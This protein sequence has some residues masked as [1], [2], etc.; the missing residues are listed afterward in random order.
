MYIFNLR[1]LNIIFTWSYFTN[2][3]PLIVVK[4]LVKILLTVFKLPVTLKEVGVIPLP[5]VIKRDR[6]DSYCSALRSLW[7]PSI[8]F[9]SE[10]LGRG[11]D[12]LV[13]SGGVGLIIGGILVVAGICYYKYYGVLI[14]HP[15]ISVVD[16]SVVLNNTVVPAPADI[17]VHVA[18]AVTPVIRDYSWSAAFAESFSPV[19]CVVFV[20]S[21]GLIALGAGAFIMQRDQLAKE[22][23]VVKATKRASKVTFAE[24]A[25]TI[26]PPIVVLTAE[27]VLL[28]SK[29][30]A[31][32]RYKA[33]LAQIDLDSAAALHTQN[34][35]ESS[36]LPANRARTSAATSGEILHAKKQ[37]Y[38]A[39]CRLH[40][41]GP[42]DVIPDFVKK[43]SYSNF[44]ENVS[45]TFST[46]ELVPASIFPFQAN[47]IKPTHTGYRF[48]PVVPTD[49]PEVAFLY[50][51][52]HQVKRLL[53]EVNRELA[54]LNDQLA[55]ETN[56]V[57]RDIGIG[58]TIRSLVAN[59]LVYSRKVAP[60]L[61]PAQAI[62]EYLVVDHNLANPGKRE[63][64]LS[65]D[66]ASTGLYFRD[67][68]GPM[69]TS[70]QFAKL[71]ECRA[72]NTILRLMHDPKTCLGNGEPYVQQSAGT[73]YIVP[74]LRPF[75]PNNELAVAANNTI[76][77]N[78]V[79]WQGFNPLLT[80]TYPQEDVSVWQKIRGFEVV[81]SPV[82]VSVG[83]TGSKVFINVTHEF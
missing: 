67:S 14:T 60:E 28:Q 72:I 16:T 78:I 59:Y 42:K 20:I 22:A 51:D 34:V 80:K 37:A 25:T 48:L 32:L 71:D 79:A 3:H 40:P 58:A 33:A 8:G 56:G 15:N 38:E 29:Q 53:D 73:P 12:F 44:G 9:D 49:I 7:V 35:K 4:A 10:T 2:R 36:I 18:K 81:S 55:S 26:E 45:Q 31:E 39:E 70:Y 19:V 11:A 52:Y 69:L 1:K 64:P 83:C 82:K 76:R 23:S 61:T 50:L 5:K 13:S 46:P 47:L 30:I 65:S 24:S 41:P 27:E 43:G 54:G 77:P 68:Q 63:L 21:I 6:H 66:L 74:V 62:R 75:C 17:I 57:Y